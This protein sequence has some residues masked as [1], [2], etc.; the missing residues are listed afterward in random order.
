MN[1]QN[2]TPVGNTEYGIAN[3]FSSISSAQ[4]LFFVNESGKI[5]QINPIY[6][7]HIGT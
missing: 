4:V 3:G 2:P 7:G 6:L 5:E 1:I